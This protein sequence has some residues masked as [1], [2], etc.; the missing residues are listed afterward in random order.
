MRKEPVLVSALAP[1]VV[2]LAARYGFQLTDSTATAIAGG[3]LVVAAPVARQMVTPLAKLGRHQT[4]P[5]P[6]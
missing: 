1:I 6:R 4:P 2:W 3:V 5:V